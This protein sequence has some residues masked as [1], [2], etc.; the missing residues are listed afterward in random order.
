MILMESTRSVHVSAMVLFLSIVLG[1]GFVVP[2]GAADPIPLWTVMVYLDSDNNLEPAGIEDFLEM[3]SVG[4]TSSVN[5]LVQMDRWD[6]SPPPADDT[7]YG[8][9]QGAMRFLVTDGMTPDDSNAL[10]DL[11]EVDMAAPATLTDFIDWGVANYPAESYAVVLWDHGAGWMGLIVDEYSGTSMDMGELTTALADASADNGGLRIDLLGFDACLMAGIEVASQVSDYA[12]IMVASE[13]T[14]PWNG[15]NYEVSF[16]PLVDEPT[17]TASEFAQAIVDG[18]VE[19]YSAPLAGYTLMDITLS[20]TDLS[21]SPY[22]E[23]AVD[24]LAIEL[25]GDLPG[26]INYISLARD[27]TEAYDDGSSA[28]VDLF[29]FASELNSVLPNPDGRN[30]TSGVMSSV[31]AAVLYEDH[32]N[33]T[34]GLSTV[35]AHGLTIYFPSGSTDYSA[36]YGDLAFLSFPQGTQWDEFLE[37]YYAFLGSDNSAPTID[38][39]SPL[40][41]PVVVSEATVFQA[42]AT[43]PDGNILTYT[44]SVGSEVLASSDSSYLNL[45]PAALGSG[46]YVLQVEVWDG[47]Y[48]DTASWNIM[49]NEAPTADAGD[50]LPSMVDCAYE[51]DGSGSTDD[52]GID[53]YT[54]SFVHDG[55]EEVLYGVSPSFVFTVPGIYEINLTVTD[56]YGLTGTDTSA[57]TVVDPSDEDPVADAGVDQTVLSGM[58]IAFDGGDST[59]D[60]GITNYTWTFVYNGTTTTLYGESPGF[61]FWTGGTYAVTLN[62]TDMAGQWDTDTVVITVSSQ[63]IPEFGTLMLP[64]LALLGVFLLVRM[65]ARGRPKG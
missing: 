33:T 39:I 50:Y 63:A 12:D 51:L 2:V 35:D 40:E 29:D 61:S 65:R 43:D 20:S 42:D 5:L 1:F 57:L 59:D 28:F 15:W 55:S 8:D 53:N 26:Y 52:W 23:T 11:G 7:S 58:S 64:V 45:D 46:T 16:A 62:V 22:V 48:S 56:I 34:G 13:V 38:E 54:W 30:L 32:W 21:L 18:Y 41:D 4:S 17:M 36:T 37:A 47:E 10:E 24:D 49:V 6:G 27:D 9:W 60:F 3:S 25:L 31:D 19:S 44:W 14:I